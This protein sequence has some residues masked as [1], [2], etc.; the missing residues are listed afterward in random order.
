MM[1]IN[2]EVKLK[3]KINK[4]IEKVD[5]FKQ[6]IAERNMQIEQLQEEIKMLQIKENCSGAK[7]NRM[8]K[9]EIFAFIQDFCLIASLIIENE[10]YIKYQYE[11]KFSG[12]FYKIEQTVFENYI[13][14]ESKMDMKTFLTYCIDLALIKSEQSRKCVYS[15]GNI[16]VYYL[17]RLFI[18]KALEREEELQEV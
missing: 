16:R 3:E 11:T 8:E 15:S 2:E 12:T 7:G 13:C 10:D 6:I 14:T 1:A 9:S 18:D 4:L 17:N 5:E